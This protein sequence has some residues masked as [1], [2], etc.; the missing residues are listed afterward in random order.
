MDRTRVVSHP[1]WCDSLVRASNLRAGEQVLVVVDEPLAAQGAELIAAVR[2]AGAEPRLELWAGERPLA[3]PPGP[4]LEA[5]GTAD[6][7][8]FLSQAPRPDEANARF[9]LMETVIG[10]GGREIYLGLVDPELLAGQLS[11]PMPDLSDEAV[12]LLAA[13]EGVETMRVR[14]AAGTDLE[15]R[16]AG[17]PWKT[18]A[19]ALTPGEVANFPGGEIFVAPHADG[20]DGLL[21]VDL[22]IPYGVDG[23]VD[24]PV[25]IRF[26]HGRAKSIEGGRSA[27]LLRKLVAGAGPGADVV[28]ELGIGLNPAVTPSGH[29]MLD[30][31]AAGTAHVA[32]GRNTGAYGGDN[33]AS[34]H[35]D[36][37]FSTPRIEADGRA[38]PLP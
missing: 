6:L 31:K 22:T 38:L 13:L 33:E 37:I 16:V 1:G 24:E 19:V 18:D 27:E 7:A 9:E 35:V 5:A 20:A 15:L 4:I 17:R 14:T 23:L 10:H 2:A 26:E 3:L 32:I 25:A 36:C 28:A 12:E 11:K 21:V 8:L 34:I 30:E 29:T